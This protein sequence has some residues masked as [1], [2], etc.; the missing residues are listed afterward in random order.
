MIAVSIL[1]LWV[2]L[3][4]MLLSTGEGDGPPTGNPSSS[5]SG[6]QASHPEVSHRATTAR[7][8]LT[9]P[10]SAAVN[11]VILYLQGGR[12]DQYFTSHALPS[13]EAYVLGCL[14]NKYPIHVFTE[15][16]PSANQQRTMRKLVPSA[17]SLDF[18][19][20]GRV[21]ATLPHGITEEAL[22]KWIAARPGFQGRGYRIMCRFWAGLVWR[23]ASMEQY[24]FYWRLDTDS[25]FLTP[26]QVDPF[27]RMV[28]GGCEYGY[29]RIKG[30]NPHVSMGLFEAYE[31]WVAIERGRPDFM[32]VNE[33]SAVRGFFVD[34]G[35][36]NRTMFY[37]NFE[38]GSFALK[39]SRVYQS[40]FEYVDG[41]EP[42]GIF[43]Y[44]WGDAPI[45]TLG[46]MAALRGNW[47]RLC[48]FPRSQVD[49]RHAMKHPPP[50]EGVCTQPLL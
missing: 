18:E 45:H 32:N 4:T 43:Q 33:V 24:D 12:W 13:L 23:L 46:V 19:D 39:R 37:N 47:S 34:N 22:R 28:V 14:A 31:R 1:A 5:V 11:G 40:L 26:I 50:R 35:A 2:C 49:Y 17:K 38:L 42:F 8:Q 36:Y 30:E 3:A 10:S 27:V 7:L 41:T 20:V 16:V 9:R 21:W 29:N 15:A 48:F 25:V 6:V 44:R